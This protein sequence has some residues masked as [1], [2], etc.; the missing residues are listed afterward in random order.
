MNTN[1]E[2]KFGG[3]KSATVEW[4][5]P[6]YIIE[7]LG[8]DFDLDPCA[9]KKD[10]YTAKKCFTKEDDGLVQDWKGFVFLNPPYSNPTIKLFMGKLSEHNNGI[11]LIYARVGN[12]MFH[13]FVWNKASSIY[14]L[15]K[16]IKFID[17]HGKEGGSP[18][19]DNCFVAYGS[20]AD[21][22]LKNLSLSG[23]YIK[24]NQ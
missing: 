10:W 2:T 15:R 20:K 16:R 13:E 22:I 5:T 21:N 12:T 17:E 23:K 4:C 9:P 14:F 7:A 6:P 3:G 1:F 24:L 19:T 18:G 11:A 8:N